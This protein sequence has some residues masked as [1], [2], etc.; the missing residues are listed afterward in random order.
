MLTLFVVLICLLFVCLT[1]WTIA[2]YF[3]NQNSQKLIREEIKNLFDIGKKFFISL[4]NL[5][6]ILA[7]YSIVPKSNKVNSDEKNI[8]R[9]D[10][11]PLTLVQTIREIEEPSLEKTYEEDDD[12]A[13]S[14]FSPEVVEVINEEEEK[15]A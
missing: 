7:T 4:K 14:S 3:V 15:I 1:G 10:E 11:K 2:T 9:K 5:I 12:T 8:L 6:V 13:L